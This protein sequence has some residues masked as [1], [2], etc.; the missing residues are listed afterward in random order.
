MK[1]SEVMTR[2]PVCCWPSSSTLTA[3]VLMQENDTGILP[4]IH[5]PF[6]PRLVGVVTDRDLCL[7]VVAAGRDP[8]STWV[9]ACMTEDP[10]Y[11]TE[12]DDVSQALALMTTH[13]VRRLPVVD[14]RHEIV[15]MVSV[16]D[17][18]C[19]AAIDASLITGALLN[20]CEPKGGP[21]RRIER[22]IA[23]AA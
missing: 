2:H 19:K 9:D 18:V 8:A 23:V 5:D 16:S 12:Q 14:D 4:V 17:L 22:I 21:Q 15:G 20:I 3:A 1:I 10:V 7:H 6:T 11:C 13:R